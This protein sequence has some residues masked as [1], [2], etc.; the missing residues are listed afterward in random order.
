MTHGSGGLP[1]GRSVSCLYAAGLGTLS[2]ND[3]FITDRGIAHRCGN[4]ITNGT[5]TPT[6]RAC[7]ILGTTPCIAARGPA[8][9][10][11]TLS[12]GAI[13]CH[14]HGKERCQAYVYG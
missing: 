2:L 3:G 4:I 10:H 12:V 8:D 9:L 7:T 14:G 5:I 1:L 6:K 13:F 11:K